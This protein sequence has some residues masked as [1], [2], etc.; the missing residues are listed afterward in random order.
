MKPTKH[1]RKKLTEVKQQIEQDTNDSPEE[2]I[3]YGGPDEHSLE[4]YFDDVDAFGCNFSDAD[5]GL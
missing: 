1:D 2:I 3:E 4:M 5:P